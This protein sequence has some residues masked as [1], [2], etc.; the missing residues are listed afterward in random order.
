MDEHDPQSTTAQERQK[1][2]AASPLRILLLEENASDAELIRETLEED[3]VCELTRVQTRAEFLA[4]L[5]N[6]SLD[7]IL[8]HYAV[9]SFDGLSA[10]KTV[11]ADRADLPFIFVSGTLGEEVAIE[12]LKLGATDYVLKTRLARLVPAVHRALREARERAERKKAEEA[13]R[14]SEAYLAEIQP[15]SHSGAFGWDLSSGEL[16]WS[17]ETFRIFDCEP[18]TKPTM[19]LVIAR[20]HPDDRTLLRQIIDRASTER[21]SFTAELRLIMPDGGLKYVQLVAHYEASESPENLFFTGAISDVTDRKRAEDTLRRHADLLNLT[22]DAMIVCDMNGNITYWNRGAEELYGW[23]AEQAVG[24]HPVELLKAVFP[25]PLDEIKE[26]LMRTGRWQGELLHK[27][28]DGTTVDVSS[29]WSL[30]RDEN[31]A[32]IAV[33]LTNTDITERKRVEQARREIEEQWRAAFEK[34][35]TMYF[36]VDAAGTIVMVNGFGAEQLGYS[37]GEL[38]GR[39]MSSVFYEA[40][41]DAVQKHF[42]ECFEQPDR[43]ITWETRK[44]RKDGTML[45]VR[46]TAKSVSLKD[47]AVLLVSCEDITQQKSAQDAARRSE[48]ELSAVI[49]TVPVMVWSTWPDGNA[50]FFNQRWQEYTGLS[51]EESLG[52]DWGTTVHPEDFDEYMRKWRAS[53][54]T[55]QPFEDEVRLRRAAD[56][57][58]RWCLDS[59]AP[60]R[61]EQG[62]ILKWYGFVADIEDRKRAEEA[63]RRSAKELHDVIE[64]VPAMVWTALPDGSVDFL[65]DRWQ[66]ITGLPLEQSLGWDWA[67]TLHP[68]ELG[69]YTEKWLAA[70]ASGEPFGGEVLLRGADGEYRCF[71]ENAVPLRDEQGNILKWVGFVVDIEDRKRAEQAA[72]RT[73]REL[74]DLIENVPAMVFISL[75]G[76]SNVFTSRGWREY[77]GLS[78]EDMAGS[79]WQRVVHP[80]DLERHMEKWRL[81]SAT[82]EPYHDEARYRAA[83]G[84]YRWFL[85]RA[86]SLRDESGEILKWYGV[87][88]DIEDRRR[89]EE[90][91]RWLNQD[92][93]RRIRE[94]T[95]QLAEANRQLAERNEE[96]ARI[97]RMKS[98]FLA[99]MSH[100]LRTP[101]NAIAGFSDL[102]AEETE[103]PLGEIYSDYV[104][105]VKKGADHLIT[106][107]NE[108]LDLSR[109]EAGR[110]E[111]LYEEFSAADAISD[112]LSVIGALAEGK[113]IDLRNLVPSALRVYADRTRFEQILYNLV[114]N[115]V[116]FTPSGGKV[117]I[118]ADPCEH[119]VRFLVS[120]TGIGIPQE[121]H[122]AIFDEFHQVGTPAPGTENGAGLGLAIT[123]RLIALHGGRIWV[124][125]APGKGSR[126]FFTMLAG[127]GS[128]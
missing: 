76:P 102:L 121:E 58:Y 19:D 60:L 48:R 29:R 50:D 114:S 41:R 21:T 15:L 98:E 49:E 65:S 36:I 59:G 112:V 40:D 75:P 91:V 4:A 122:N 96:L 39:P 52:W 5:Q 89:A 18:A 110:V 57:E 3:F 103:G 26:V 92:L 95:A 35:P 85:V 73:E 51:L 2:I 90:E 101:L 83:D 88:T 118:I 100:E 9:P 37:G 80:E 108:V 119:E 97:S 70:L 17:D 11:L 99:R 20:T 71:L 53:L 13:L 28:R 74:R 62:N 81:C 63:A 84:G 109:I 86:V 8:S 45:W 104:Q 128:E 113:G 64:N 69:P 79:G 93:E 68:E 107:V 123:K 43:A 117:R 94:R 44:I 125:S 120:D 127:E 30:Q 61:D 82:G 6:P 111:L 33:L 31:G 16:I 67:P 124:E 87:L 77:T 115:A 7:V 12:A 1:M 116:K 25:V 14:R 105:H 10:L 32:P 126:F 38:L 72:R 47:R 24:R 56:G 106:L 46:E 66:D 27:T 22:H 34:N 23:P 42:Q 78:A 54:A 55:G